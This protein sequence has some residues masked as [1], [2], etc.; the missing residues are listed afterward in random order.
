MD[1]SDYRYEEFITLLQVDPS[2]VPEGAVDR[3]FFELKLLACRAM[4]FVK[5]IRGRDFHVTAEGVD[6]AKRV[7]SYRGAQFMATL[8]ADLQGDVCAHGKDANEEPC[9]TCF[10]H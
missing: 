9:Y 4:G 5:G 10:K 3:S 8:K 6:F 2:W 7:R 1:E